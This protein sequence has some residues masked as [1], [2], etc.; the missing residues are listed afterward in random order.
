MGRLDQRTAAGVRVKPRPSAPSNIYEGMVTKN[1]HEGTYTVN[2]AGF[3]ESL[4]PKARA[5][6]GGPIYANEPQA[7]IV[8][9]PPVQGMA[10]WDESGNRVSIVQPTGN[11]VTQFSVPKPYRG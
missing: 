4:N 3:A 8:Q 5:S 11:Q 1:V 7:A 2:N 9:L 6:N 10:S